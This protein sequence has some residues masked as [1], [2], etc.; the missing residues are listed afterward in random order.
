MCGP[1]NS[2]KQD[3]L[4]KDWKENKAGGYSIHASTRDK[5]ERVAQQA[6][7]HLEKEVRKVPC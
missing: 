2:S 7:R 6:K 4:W 3:T 5:G 1:C